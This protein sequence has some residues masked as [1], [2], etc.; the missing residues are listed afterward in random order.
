MNKNLIGIS[1]K[2]GS[3]KD[4]FFD[5]VQK[6]VDGSYENKKFAFKLKQI[7]SILT[8]I[9]PEKFED[10]EFKKTF[11]SK[12][13]DRLM[14]SGDPFLKNEQIEVFYQSM[15]V[16]EFLQRLGTEAMRDGLHKNVWV[17]ALLSDFNK[18]TSKWIVTDM[19]FKNELSAIKKNGGIT[20]RINRKDCVK[21]DHPSETE[22]DSESF[23][24]VIEN[25]GT[26]EEF[27]EKIND[28]LIKFNII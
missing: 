16:R 26:L 24:Y 19:R 9:S 15:T 21:I 5:I 6:K 2:I 23:D 4:T 14:Y 18:E 25:N 3:G 10:Q 22:L 1:A 28:F 12:E 13:W 17:N 7:A 27:E 11:L 20:V 8:G